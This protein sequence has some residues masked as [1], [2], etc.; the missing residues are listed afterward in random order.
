[1]NYEF[2][3]DVF[4]LTNV[5]LDFCAI[6]AVGEVL[7]QKKKRFRYLIGS[8]ISSFLG[9]IL[10]VLIEKYELY[11]LLIHFVVNPAMTVFCFYP[12]AKSVYGKAFGLMYFIILLLGGTLEWLYHTVA[13]GRGYELCLLLTAIPVCIF[14]F[15]LRQKR[16]NVRRLYQVSVE[17]KGKKLT[18]QALYDTGNSL[19]DPYVGKPIHIVSRRIWDSLGEKQEFAIRLVPFSSVGCRRGLLEAF[20]VDVLQVK[21]TEEW[22]IEPAVL[23]VA[24][25]SLFEGRDYEMILNSNIFENKNRNEEEI[26]T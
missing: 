6:Y 5:Y 8:A 11:M 18:L 3:A 14:L 16:K 7:E 24:E 10:F 4:F 20:N 15:I 25:E 9:C 13:G 23:A 21:G 17:Y 22:K 26:C 19:Q 2:Y 1:M 12:A